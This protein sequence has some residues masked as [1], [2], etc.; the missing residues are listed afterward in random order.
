MR[1]CQRDAESELPG[2]VWWWSERTGGVRFDAAT[3]VRPA[4]RGGR[5]LSCVAQT[6][7]RALPGKAVPQPGT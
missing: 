1:V 6:P 4:V 2:Q 3:Q 5:L 7:R